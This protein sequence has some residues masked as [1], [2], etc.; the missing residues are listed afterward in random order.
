M[1]QSG[2]GMKAATITPPE[3][4]DVG[5][6]NAILREEIDGRVILRTGRRIPRVRPVGGV[7]SPIS[8]VRMAVDDAY[9][10]KEWRENTADGDELAYRTS[11]ISRKTCRFVAE[12]SFQLAEQTGARV[13]GGP[14][15]TV[16]PVYEG[17]FKEELDAAATRHPNVSYEPQLID[18]TLA[19]LI[20][21]DGESLV[22]PTLNR[23]GD[24]L[25]DMILQM[26]GSIA[27][28][29]SQVLAFDDS[30]QVRVV[31]TEA[32]HGTAPA[33]EG[34]NIAN[35]MA[36]ILAGGA[37]LSYIHTPKAE[38]ASRAIYESVFEALHDGKATT[39]LGGRLSTTEFT[40]EV[41]QRVG[42]KLEVWS[43]L[44]R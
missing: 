39:D 22:I 27:G 40:D 36:M 9:G 29:E 25:S 19:L 4:N 20:K 18:A 33:L 26:F 1:N 13:F 15:Y 32:P 16:S 14:K 41:I 8:I 30:M 7:H 38:R 3:K 17:M 43:G 37:I 42:A 31:M 21:T 6:P 24:L 35:P 10:A 11:K 34:K 44:R 23:D 2:L 28:S 12:F 5:S